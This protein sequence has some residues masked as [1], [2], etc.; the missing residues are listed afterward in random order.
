MN[1]PSFFKL[2]SAAIAPPAVSVGRMMETMPN[3]LFRKNVGSG[4]IRLVWNSSATFGSVD[5][6]RFGNVT[7]APVEPGN[8]VSVSVRRIALPA[9][10]CQVW[11]CEVS[12]GPIES[13]TRNTSA[14]LTERK[15]KSSRVGDRLRVDRYPSRLARIRAQVGV[16]SRNGRVLAH[17]KRRNRLIEGVTQVG[18]FGIAP[19]ACPPTRVDRQ[20]GQVG[21]P[22]GI[23][24]AGNLARRQVEKFAE[25]GHRV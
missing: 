7:V 16:C 5:P 10:S 4:M 15:V 25:I 17:R 19:V 1:N 3:F 9:L 18:V 12:V 6:L 20:L 21:E 24:D 2:C 8:P 22:S 11:K 23:W 14:L 13:R